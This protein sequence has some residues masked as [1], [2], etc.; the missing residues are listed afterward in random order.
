M[1]KI[2][3][4]YIGWIYTRNFLIVFAALELFYVGIDI[5]SNF[6]NIPSSANLQLLYIWFLAISATS[7]T[8][9]LSLIFSLIVSKISLI[10]SNELVSFYALG[11]DKKSVIMPQF[12]IA[13]F[14]TC[15]FVGLNFTP[16]AYAQTYQ[17][18][19]I[20]T[21]SLYSSIFSDVF[22]KFDGKFI[23][24]NS[25]NPGSSTMSGVRI[26]SVEG[27]NLNS[28]ISASGGKFDGNSWQLN[29]I[30]LTNIPK[31]LSLGGAGLEITR[32][33]NL[34]TLEGFSPK[35]IESASSQNSSLSTIDALDFMFTFAKEGVRVDNVRAT[36]YSLLF[37]PFFAPLL[38]IILYCY[39]PIIGR[40]SSLALSGF[41][42]VIV[43]FV[44][45]GGLFVLARLSQNSVILPELGI[46]APVAI[47]LIYAV[48]LIRR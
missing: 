28:V 30:N 3:L 2:Y 22:L 41:V 19:L 24:I 23:Y 4:R 11:I 8:V 13:L 37:T 10:R 44:V 46:L 26:F 27:T 39:M 1:K 47:M 14:I 7:Y 45:W 20:K 38:V 33:K 9:P 25:L 34:K 29:D 18:N 43:T 48:Y 40:F 15:L 21:G 6:K 32:F 36:F 31:N 17:K 16:F 12:L 35:S 42:M 5:L